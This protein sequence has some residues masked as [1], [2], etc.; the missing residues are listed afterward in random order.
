MLQR[1]GWN[2]NVGVEDD[3][4]ASSWMTCDAH[5]YGAQHPNFLCIIIAALE[6]EKTKFAYSRPN[7]NDGTI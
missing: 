6:V 5:V 3:R 2:G 7:L 1:K 4:I